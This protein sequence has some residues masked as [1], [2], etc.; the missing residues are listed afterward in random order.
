MPTGAVQASEFAICFDHTLGDPVMGIS[1]LIAASPAAPTYILTPGL[2][3]LAL[4]GIGAVQGRR[5]GAGF[6]C[7]RL[8]GDVVWASLA[9]LAIV[10]PRTI[11]GVVFDVL[12]LLCVS[13]SAGS[14]GHL[15]AR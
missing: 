14:P 13:I 10:G 5:A 6:L 3:V 1:V 15:Q 11:D 9:L 12:G 2:A 4:L 7:G 8:V